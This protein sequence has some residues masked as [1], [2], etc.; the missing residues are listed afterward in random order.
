MFES[1]SD[2]ASRIQCGNEIRLKVLDGIPVIQPGDDLGDLVSKAIKSSHEVL[3]SGDIIA[4]PSKLFSRTENRFVTLQDVVVSAEAETLA[5]EVQKDARLVQLI[6]DESTQVSRKCPGVLIVRHR[7]GH[8]SANAGID[9]SNANL[10]GSAGDSVLLLPLNPDES[11]KR[12]RIY[13]ENEFGVQIGVV[14]T[15]SLGRPFRFGTVGHA[16][17]CSGLPA[18]WDQ[19]GDE[20]LFGRALEHTVTAFADQLAAAADLV[21]G[22]GSEGRGAVLIRGMDFPAFEQSAQELHRPAEKDLYA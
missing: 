15:D 17:G 9:A 7:L 5:N 19:V 8:I 22:Q 4:L 6:L 20:D 10:K 21:L 3:L 12:L 11:A 14:V 16:L 13:L 18:L 2:P 1:L